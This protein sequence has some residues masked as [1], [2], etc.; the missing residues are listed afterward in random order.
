M[1]RMIRT[2][3]RRLGDGFGRWPPDILEDLE[4]K[5]IALYSCCF[6]NPLSNHLV[7]YDWFLSELLSKTIYLGTPL[8][9]VLDCTETDDDD[10]TD[11]D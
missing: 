8:E 2:C 10:D 7:P 3:R 9:R 5:I 11:D 4:K 6:Y 1:E